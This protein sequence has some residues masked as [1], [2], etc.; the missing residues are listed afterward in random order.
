MDTKIKEKGSPQ[1]PDKAVGSG[2]HPESLD[3][4]ICIYCGRRLAKPSAAKSHMRICKF[5]AVTSQVQTDCEIPNTTDSAEQS[6]DRPLSDF[7]TVPDMTKKVVEL[8][9]RPKT[10]PHSKPDVGSKRP[11]ACPGST[12]SPTN[13]DTPKRR[14]V[15][16]PEDS[17]SR[18]QTNVI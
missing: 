5:K 13:S 17:P 16:C 14:F 8:S 12:L 2:D 9:A 11:M 18:V 7:D 6:S 10:L 1:R 4:C 15:E 3:S